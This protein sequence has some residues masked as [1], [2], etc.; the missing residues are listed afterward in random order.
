[1]TSQKKTTS[2]NEVVHGILVDAPQDQAENGYFRAFLEAEAD[3]NNRPLA[4]A[5]C[6]TSKKGMYIAAANLCKR[7]SKKTEPPLPTTPT[8]WQIYFVNPASELVSLQSYGYLLVEQ[9]DEDSFFVAHLMVPPLF[10]SSEDPSVIEEYVQQG[11]L[12]SVED[13]T[14]QTG[15]GALGN[16]C[17][18]LHRH[19]FGVT[20]D[21]LVLDSLTAAF[22]LPVALKSDD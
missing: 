12:N 14:G 7:W 9:V 20:V 8:K 21:S 4:T 19:G 13:A 1:M 10:V 15:F 5:I 18:K 2:P 3:G 11:W 17:L 22:F 16:L 6:S